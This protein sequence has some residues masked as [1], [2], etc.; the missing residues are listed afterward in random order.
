VRSFHHHRI[1]QIAEKQR[2]SYSVLIGLW[3]IL[4]TAML[5][6]NCAVYKLNKASVRAVV[7]WKERKKERRK[8]EAYEALLFLFAFYRVADLTKHRQ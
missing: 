4:L 3:R 7:D 2:E 8:P 6:I 1:F 5:Y